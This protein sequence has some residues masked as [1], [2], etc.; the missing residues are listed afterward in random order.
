MYDA[1]DKTPVLVLSYT[2]LT[3]NAAKPLA[4]LIIDA[5]SVKDSSG[6]PCNDIT[7][8]TLLR[9]LQANAKLINPSY[10]PE[11]EAN[12]K[13]LNKK[14]KWKLT[15]LF[16][17][18]A[19]PMADVGKLSVDAVC[20]VCGSTKGVSQCSNCMTVAYC[21]PGTDL[22]SSPYAG[23]LTA[24]EECQK[25]DWP[26]HKLRCDNLKGGTWTT[27]NLGE[28]PTSPVAGGGPLFMTNL[29]IHEN[30]QSNSNTKTSRVGGTIPNTHGDKM[31]MVKFQ[32]PGMGMSDPDHMYLYDQKRSFRAF[33]KQSEDPEAFEVGN[34]SL[35]GYPKMYRWARFVSG[36]TLSVCFDKAPAEMPPW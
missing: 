21:S 19:I 15:F 18:G 28:N 27:I 6:N 22:P 24:V 13:F 26:R 5:V 23:Q 33:W 35:G 32:V 25:S 4:K 3:D 14:R 30:L 1:G 12:Q 17:L 34:R 31:F 36:N 20:D 10:A 29:N 2:T 8:R 11:G 9:L 16:P 7:R